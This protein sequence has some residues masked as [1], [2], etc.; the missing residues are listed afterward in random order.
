M[1][2]QNDFDS[3]TSSAGEVEVAN[4]TR[5]LPRRTVLAGA[6]WAVPAIIV[7][8]AAPAAAASLTPTLTFTNG[9]FAT[10]ACSLIT[11]TLQATTDGT[12]PA[13]G[14]LITVTP[15]E[16]F[17]WS[18]GS[19]SSRTFTTD[20]SGQ[21][22]LDGLQAVYYDDTFTLTATSTGAT[23]STS[24][25]VDANGTAHQYNATSLTYLDH[26]SIPTGS[27]AVGGG[28]F[29]TPTG[30]LMLNDGTVVAN[31]VDNAI[32]DFE[33]GTTYVTY[34]DSTGAHQYNA[35]S[36]TY[37]DHPSIPTGSVAVGGGFFL[38]PTGTLMLND[39]TIVANNVDN[40]IGTFE[41]GTTYVTYVDST[42][43][44]QYNATSLTYLD[45]PSIPTGSVAVG[46]GFFLTPTG[47]LM[48]NDGTVVANNVDNA[49][50]TFESGTTYVTYV[51]STG[52]HQ[53]NATSLTYLDHPSIPTGS[54]AVGGGF[55]LTPTGTL[56]LNN[57]T[58]V[59]NNVDTAIGDFES[60]F[61]YV[62][63]TT[64]GC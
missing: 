61:T 42:G 4:E 33:S 48:L 46:G 40:A 26:P 16:G 12:T 54:V 24:I 51:D 9:P 15:P 41:S 57:G 58:I 23:A 25:T 59:A 43:A 31:N 60:G 29:L 3:T 35:T 6:A 2:E 27:V 47:T 28:F 55:F 7:A 64:T 11:P 52:A 63:Y 5:G 32:G 38:T 13:V 18:D 45:H 14:E 62:T 22:T 8:T 49:I 36:L 30:T 20:G 1:T 39:G 10:D 56:M 17:T 44:H 21:V 50:G 53:Y 34:V 37:L 19:T